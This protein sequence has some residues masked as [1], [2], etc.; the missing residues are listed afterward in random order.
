MRK[1]SKRKRTFANRLHRDLFMIVFF[2]AFLPASVVAVTLY[3]LIFGI[4]ANQF[5]IP[6]AI[7]YNI[8]PASRKVTT[9]LAFAAPGTILIILLLAHKITHTMVGPFDRIVRELDECVKDKREGHI[10]VRKGDRFRPLVD[11]INKL[12]DKLG[13][14]K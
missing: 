4:T 11:K 6:E 9:I 2:A 12:L 3:Y 13:L 10:I 8:I 14:K 5:G 1:S 7:A